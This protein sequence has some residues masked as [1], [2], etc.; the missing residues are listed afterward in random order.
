MV[1]CNSSHPL[2]R[3]VS[4]YTFLPTNLEN[5]SVAAGGGGTSRESAQLLGAILIAGH[6]VDFGDLYA[7]A[8]RSRIELLT[9]EL[10]LAF[11]FAKLSQQYRDSSNRERAFR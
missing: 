2:K 7:A 11:N 9:L 8:D 1:D 4:V 10:D 5:S 3:L 6:G